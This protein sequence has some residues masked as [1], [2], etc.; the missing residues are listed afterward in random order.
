MSLSSAV[1]DASNPVEVEADQQVATTFQNSPGV[2]NGQK[3]PV[4]P[5]HVGIKSPDRLTPKKSQDN[6]QG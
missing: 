4:I 3:L 5:Y 6:Q 2:K 1:A